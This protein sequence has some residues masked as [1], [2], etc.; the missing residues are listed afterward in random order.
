MF[1]SASEATPKRDSSLR[2]VHRRL[3]GVTTAGPSRS[4]SGGGARVREHARELRRHQRG[5]ER[6]ILESRPPDLRVGRAE[7]AT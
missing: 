7:E 2:A 4:A 3:H 5:G 1:F 6:G